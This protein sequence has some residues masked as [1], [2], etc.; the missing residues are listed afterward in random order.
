VAVPVPGVLVEKVRVPEA[1][2]DSVIVA[3]SDAEQVRVRVRV[4]VPSGVGLRVVVEVG[5]RV[6]WLRDAVIVK[7]ML[8]LWDGLMDTERLQ[9]SVRLRLS[10]LVTVPDLPNDR[11]RLSLGVNVGL[12]VLEGRVRVVEGLLDPVGEK[13]PERVQVHVRASEQVWVWVRIRDREGL[14]DSEPV[15]LGD[16]VRVVADRDTVGG[17]RLGVRVSVS[18]GPRVGGLMD[19]V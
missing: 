5:V 6:P 18:V 1:E 12:Q 9:V 4:L 3:F 8:R 17:V 10:V 14:G 2:E 13:L 19:T 7:L 15:G 16:R 11:V